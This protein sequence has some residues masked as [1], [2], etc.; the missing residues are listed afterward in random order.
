[1]GLNFQHFSLLNCCRY[2][3]TLSDGPFYLFV[4]VPA[5]WV[6]AVLNFI[7][8][9]EGQGI[10][11]YNNG[12]H[13]GTNNTKHITDNEN[14]QNDGHIE[15]GRLVG[16]IQAHYASVDVDE[17]YFFNR[18]LTDAEIKSLSQNCI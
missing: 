1:M 18:T 16:L 6:H 3:E 9:D 7:G 13:V 17:L 8:P 11:I 14:G 15:V 10:S 4:G 2:I 12:N 5:G